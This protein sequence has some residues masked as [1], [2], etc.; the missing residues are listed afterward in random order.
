M[1]ETPIDFVPISHFPNPRHAYTLGW[2]W[3]SIDRHIRQSPFVVSGNL[4]HEIVIIA[5]S[6][7]ENDSCAIRRTRRRI[8]CGDMVGCRT[9]DLEVWRATGSTLKARAFSTGQVA[10]QGE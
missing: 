6:A 1:N 10:W 7:R 2:F 4:S 5:E 9:A 8:V 3:G